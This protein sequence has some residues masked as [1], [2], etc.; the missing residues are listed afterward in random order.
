MSFRP[1]RALLLPK[2]DKKPQTAPY[3]TPRA[4][5]KSF[6]LPTTG[7]S[8]RIVLQST[9][10]L[11]ESNGMQRW[12]IDS[13]SYPVAPPCKPVL[14]SVNDDPDWVSNV[15]PVPAN[16]PDQSLYFTPK[17]GDASTWEGDGK[18]IQVGSGSRQGMPM[19]SIQLCKEF[20][21]HTSAIC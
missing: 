13:I 20:A 7:I 4:N 14:D 19:N 18:N 1:N 9:Q 10:P 17:G 11:L 15:S 3:F 8:R 16:G 21:M 6:K 5:I 2:A 12:A